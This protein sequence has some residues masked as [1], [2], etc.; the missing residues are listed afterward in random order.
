MK[1]LTILGQKWKVKFTN[2]ELRTE[3]GHIIAGYCSSSHKEIVISTKAHFKSPAAFIEYVSR[4]YWHEILHAVFYEADFRDQSY[5]HG[6]M[7]HFLI[8][9]IANFLAQNFPV[10]IDPKT[11]KALMKNF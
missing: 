5:W 6:D 4:T 10:Q 1:K 3:Q 9:P 11:L 2:K 8:A 7:E